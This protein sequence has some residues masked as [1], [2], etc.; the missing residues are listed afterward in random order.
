M[1]RLSWLMGV[2]CLGSWVLIASTVS[3][4][5]VQITDPATELAFSPGSSHT[6][7]ASISGLGDHE[8]EVWWQF[9]DTAWEEGYTVLRGEENKTVEV[10]LSHTF[11]TKGEFA[12]TVWVQEKNTQT[13]VSDSRGYLVIQ[14]SITSETHHHAQDGTADTRT[15]LG[16]GETVTCTLDADPA[17]PV[18][19]GVTWSKTGGRWGRVEGDD[20][21]F[22]ARKSPETCTIKATVGR[23]EATATFT[24]VAPTGVISSNPQDQLIGA[25][26]Q[27]WMGCYTIVSFQTPPVDVSFEA[28]TMREHIRAGS[29]TWPDQ[30][31]FVWG[32]EDRLWAC[33]GTDHWADYYWRV[34]SPPSC[35]N[36][37]ACSWNLV[38]D[39]QYVD[40]AN[41]WLT[42]LEGD[43]GVFSYQQPGSA[44]VSCGGVGSGWMGP[45]TGKALKTP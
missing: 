4:L 29:A 40:D 13:W 34:Q 2:V 19:I 25:A 12:A 11:P 17:L 8:Y 30:T 38:R 43:V 24:V 15:K 39:L 5:Q 26:G 1:K 10:Q 14:L 27:T 18:G 3:A 9:T 36:G 22:T 31:Q 23:A 45:F 21:V 41:N 32:V 42:Y 28:L 6:F 33:M 37:G 20:Y 7:K 35:L 44:K 16:L